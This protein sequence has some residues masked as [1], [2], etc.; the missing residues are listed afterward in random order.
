MNPINKSFSDELTNILK[1]IETKLISDF[2]S[3]NI[4]SEYFI[5]GILENKNCFAYAALEECLMNEI[6]NG[7]VEEYSY[8]LSKN[9][10]PLNQFDTPRFSDG[11]NEYLIQSNVERVKH[12]HEKIN[13]LHVILAMLFL[14]G[15]IKEM[16]ETV[17][18][19][20]DM[21]D[22]Y[23]IKNEC[24]ISIHNE[25]KTKQLPIKV[26]KNINNTQIVKTR[27]SEK[28]TLIDS[29]SQNLNE[30]ALKGDIDKV[31]GREKEFNQIFNILGRRNKNNLIL[32]G[33]GGCGKT[34]ICKHLANLI[35]EKKAPVAY[36]KKK[37][38]QL[39]ISSMIAGANFKGM[40]ESRL[41]GFLDEIK[42]AK[43]YIIFIDDIHTALSEKNQAGDVNVASML[44]N[45]L[46]DGDIQVIGTTN[47]KD[48][49]NTIENNNSLSRRFQKVIVE[50]SSVDESITI[51][52][53]CKESYES[54]HNVK[55]TNEA[56]KACVLLANK[57]ISER[58]LPDSAIDLLDE[59]ASKV[60]LKIKDTIEITNIKNELDKI[61]NDKRQILSNEL[62]EGI[63]DLNVKENTLKIKLSLLEKN[64]RYNKEQRTVSED[65]ICELV[66]E[67][68][69]I[70]ITKLNITE[71]ESLKNIN[72]VL[73]N[74]IIG[75]D[76]A[77]DKICQV[78]KR[79][80]VGLSNKNKPIVMFLGG[81]TGVGKT[82]IAK[83]LAKEVFGDEKYLVR[84]DMSEYSEKSSITKLIGSAPG[85]V[86]FDNGGQL[87]EIIKTKKYCVLLLDEIEKANQD[88]Y[89]VFLQLFDE[90]CLTDN[91]GQKIDFKN[92]II[93]LTS[94]TGAKQVSDFGSGLGLV[95]NEQVNT[96]IIIQKELKKKFP[97]EFI[98]RID[99]IIYFNKL[100]D[101][102][103]KEIIMLELHN[104]NERLK[105]IGLSFGDDIYEEEFINYLFDKIKGENEYG[106]RPVLRI[107]QEIV[108]NQISD[109]ILNTTIIMDNV[110]HMKDIIHENI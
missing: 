17:G 14:D 102:N 3:K 83:K 64:N 4:V 62:Y 26:N 24:N 2:P 96:K 68:T 56:V 106:A 73:K 36:H 34:A 88:I 87:T 29:F 100:T 65:D 78:V 66:A 60:I 101:D 46:I 110:L 18:L 47:F 104:L 94:N 7:I 1:Y 49:K 37:I 84:L 93:L 10:I 33:N 80:R 103:I 58:N 50:P 39:D 30:L 92:V 82:L 40:F 35:V 71:K 75:Q 28:N 9:P 22:A 70:P 45:I 44:N 86:G 76:E 90:G 6:I 38:V 51:L 69:S 61:K 108:E 85:Y 5:I 72:K 25:V 23:I 42:T 74:S 32:I 95:R 19:T 79:S 54:Y 89:N 41:K 27:K 63:Y 109:I 13:T 97:P 81:P 43:N 57:Y 99:D 77:I 31:V 105:E 52:N 15:K 107:I 20:Y 67:K 48:Y 12:N 8:Y 59:S 21:F 98:N 16:F 55:Y 53:E 11:F 91:T